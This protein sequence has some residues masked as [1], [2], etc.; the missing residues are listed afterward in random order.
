[1]AYA[2]IIPGSLFARKSMRDLA[3]TY[4]SV[5]CATW[6]VLCF[7]GCGTK[8]GAG[9]ATVFSLMNG[10]VGGGRN[11]GWYATRNSRCN[12]WRAPNNPVEFC[13]RTGV[14]VR[15]LCPYAL[16]IDDVKKD[17]RERT[18][19]WYMQIPEDVDPIQQA[20]G[21]ILLIE[22]GEQRTYD[23][24]H[25]GSRRLLVVPLGRGKPK[26]K[27]EEYTSG[28][29]RNVTHKARRLV[30]SREGSE[31]RFRVLLYPFRTT[32]EPAGKTSREHWEKSPLGAVI[33][34][35]NPA[36]A[37]GFSLG[38][39]ERTDE[40]KLTP[41]EDGRSRICLQRGEEEWRID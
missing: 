41:G 2:E 1:M 20:D 11:I 25:V 15:G 40:W 39:D 38:L 27:L 31:G 23:R 35:H 7:N 21:S 13:W 32:I 36:T 4:G 18:Y 9:Q 33:P 37:D 6:S 26:V 5:E 29:S 34:S 28:I 22:K 12:L 10:S 24:P 19:D 16:M 17:E 30:I 14:L 8:A 3:P